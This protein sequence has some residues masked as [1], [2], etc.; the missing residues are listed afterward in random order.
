MRNIDLKNSPLFVAN[1]DTAE[2]IFL[3]RMAWNHACRYSL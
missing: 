2:R 3:E 1:T